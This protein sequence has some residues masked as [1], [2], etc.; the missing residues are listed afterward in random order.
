VQCEGR[1]RALSEI[2]RLIG[3]PL[4][5][6]PELTFAVEISKGEAAALRAR[7]FTRRREAQ[8]WSDPTLR[9]LDAADCAQAAD[10]AALAVAMAI[11]SHLAERD[12]AALDPHRADRTSPVDSAQVTTPV[13][14]PVPVPW[15]ALIGLAAAMDYG[16]LPKLAWGIEGQLALQRK[17]ARL[18]G[19][20]S[21]FPRQDGHVATDGRGGEFSLLLGGLLG[22]GHWGIARF[23]L[24]TC[25]G[26]ELG[27][28]RAEGIGLD[29][30]RN[31]SG[32][33]R[34][35]RLEAGVGYDVVPRLSLVARVGACVPWGRPEF[36]VE[37]RD[38][39]YRVAPVTVRAL[40]GLAWRL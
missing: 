13:P 39:V 19:L 18:T 37:E 26:I 31:V 16:A 12:G 21:Y 29:R 27:A 8:I 35:A 32:F 23:A 11:G 15:Y 3:Q 17:A 2:E 20:V 1:E 7:I 33:W 5:E 28:L 22:C 4:H 34:A 10:A 14:A 6:V 9:E 40:L 30:P 36:T 25:G 38:R 24:S